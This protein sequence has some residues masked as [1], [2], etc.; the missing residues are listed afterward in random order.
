MAPKTNREVVERFVQGLIARDLDVQAEVC[1]SDMVV[2]YPQ[3][4][5]RIRGWANVRAVAD[6]YPG[7][8]PEDLT[9]KV[10]GSQSGLEWIVGKTEVMPFSE[11]VRRARDQATEVKSDSRYVRFVIATHSLEWVLENGLP[12]EALEKSG[13]TACNSST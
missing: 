2:E 13:P 1:A 10:L 3:S 8:L 11:D 6:N 5:E 12:M 9:S 7:G 4:G